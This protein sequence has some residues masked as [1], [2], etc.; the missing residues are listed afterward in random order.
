MEFPL[1][2]PSFKRSSRSSSFK[3]GHHKDD[4]RIASLD[5]DEEETHTEEHHPMLSHHCRHDP[6]ASSAP[7][8]AS[9]ASPISPS[10]GDVIV[11]IEAPPSTSTDSGAKIRSGSIRRASSDTN[12]VGSPWREDRGN[13]SLS[14]EFSFRRPEDE[15]GNKIHMEPQTRAEPQNPSKAAVLI[16]DS[17]S[18]KLIGRF[19]EHQR[20]TTKANLSAE[21]ELEMEDLQRRQLPPLPPETLSRSGWNRNQS[22]I[23]SPSTSVLSDYRN[24]MGTVRNGSNVNYNFDANLRENRVSFQESLISEPV[25]HGSIYSNVDEGS[26]SSSSISREDDDNNDDIDSRINAAGVHSR[27]TMNRNSGSGASP[28]HCGEMLRSGSNN[29]SVRRASISLGSKTKSR[30]IDRPPI[31]LDQRSGNLQKSGMIN[32]RF[33]YHEEEDDPSFDDDVPEEFKQAQIGTLVFLEWVSL[34]ALTG[35]L[36]CSLIIPAL[37]ARTLLKM[38]L[39]KWEVSILVLICGRLVSGWVVRIIVFFIERN[40]LLR[41]RVLYFVYGLKKAV[42]NVIWLGLVLLTW[43]LLFDKKLERE[44][45][46][47]PLRTVT[48]LL[49]IGEVCAVVWLFK[50]LLIKVCASNFHVNAFF[51]R[52]QESLF[53]QFVIETLSGPPLFSFQQA[54]VDDDR[55]IAEVQ[56]LQNAGISVPPDLKA[57]MFP[58]SKSTKSLLPN[59][60]EKT[61]VGG[62][63]STPYKSPIGHSAGLSGSNSKKIDEGITIDH[64]HKLNQKNV[65]AWGMKRLMR[66]VRYGTLTTLDEQITDV[67]TQEDESATQIKSTSI[68][69]IFCVLCGKMRLSRL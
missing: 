33:D 62:S 7:E 8:L 31:P 26:S 19:L 58:R 51:D 63:G 57:S 52:I 13:P 14:P 24:A 25:G 66:I 9:P 55:T 16:E 54:Q 35:A 41:K 42:Q 40:F 21:M 45:N 5:D 17:A 38:S 11:K 65:S 39:W 34:V 48:R 49:V 10:A 43:H 61:P 29:D 59:Q 53:D 20:T 44:A 68:W 28:N 22:D 6:A 32:T 69:M 60:S 27:R 64:L 47:E 23:L 2:R 67:N 37:K 18:S 30:L 12:P 36:I 3:Q 56:M 15:V 1:R 50:T 46:S 4:R